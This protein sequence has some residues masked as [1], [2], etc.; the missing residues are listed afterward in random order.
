MSLL[1][2]TPALSPRSLFESL[3]RYA[4]G[5]VFLYAAL[6]KIIDPHAFSLDIANYRLLPDGLLPYAAL[7]VPALEL[8]AGI[9]VIAG[10]MKGEAAAWIAL[11][12]LGFLFGEGQA[13]LRGL[14]LSCGCFGKG[15]G[16]VG[17]LSIGRNALL[18]A[19][20]VWVIL[21]QRRYRADFVRHPGAAG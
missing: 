14:D 11:L 10:P 1:P 6:S 12:L 4:L 21:E 15:S 5:G 18:L 7:L 8:V 9:F 2:A 19:A 3:L 17:W 13:I 16:K 20:S